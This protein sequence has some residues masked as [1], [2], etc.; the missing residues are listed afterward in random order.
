MP[1]SAIERT[2]EQL[3]GDKAMIRHLIQLAAD[4]ELF[5]IPL[6]MTTLYSIAG[7]KA[8]PDGSVYPYMGPS[9][10]YS[11]QGLNAQRS[12]NAIFSVY[13]QEMLHLQLAMNIGN[14]LGASMSLTQPLYPHPEKGSNW[15]PCLGELA[16]L[17]PTKYPEFKNIEVKLD[18][19]SSN[20]INL[21]MAIELP[22]EESFVAPPSV[23]LDCEPADVFTMTF[24]GIGNLY[25]TIQKYLNFQY[26]PHDQNPAGLNLFEH[27]YTQAVTEASAKGKTIIQ[28]NQFKGK[29]SS[30]NEHMVLEVTPGA[31]CSKAFSDVNEMINAI[32]SEGE[33]S[34][35][36]NYN[37][38]SPN[39]Q[40]SASDDIAADRLWDAYSHWARFELVKGISDDV[41]TWPKFRANRLA[42]KQAP[43]VWADLVADPL[44]VTQSQLALAQARA[45]AWNN[46]S[47]A[48]DLNAILNSTFNRFLGNMNDAWSG[49]T[50]NS[51]AMGSMQAISSRV[52]SVWAAGGVPEFKKPAHH[53]PDQKPLHACQG[54]NAEKERG[55]AIGECDCSTAI[56][57]S[58][59]TSN[60]CS[61]Q[62]GCGYPF[63][64]DNEGNAIANSPL[65]FIPGENTK[66]GNGG[67][68]APIPYAQVFHDK[69]SPSGEAGSFDGKQ[70]WQRARE[71][72]CDKHAIENKP[73]TPSSIRVILPP[74]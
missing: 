69:V 32:V 58:C 19:L 64:A 8:M 52:T 21:F 43:F 54:L 17:N 14:A 26:P 16:N 13:I 36:N 31:H 24:G 65:N 41:E 49:A 12:Y 37:F 57:H 9:E 30:Y 61:H 35:T 23:P 53:H 51:L 39:Y 1:A 7:R 28:V 42:Q 59:V 70:V 72:F 22:D 44:A 20:S 62:G 2:L 60:S 29:H 40:P 47:T 48:D 73:L 33:G 68:G 34:S 38:V 10:Q 27:C 5:T 3:E 18:A 74:S 50:T 71:L 56:Q 66:A 4:V 15:V 46:D 67:C 25:T 6:Y 63:K 45:E 55:F 11:M